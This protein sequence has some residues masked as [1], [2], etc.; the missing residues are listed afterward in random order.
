MLRLLR[1]GEGADTSHLEQIQHGY[2]KMDHFTANVERQRRALNNVDFLRCK[3]DLRPTAT[4]LLALVESAS[5]L[6]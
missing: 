4:R 1:L 3:K 5:A 6:A 2:Q